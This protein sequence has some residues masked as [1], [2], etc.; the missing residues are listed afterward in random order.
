MKEFNC[1]EIGSIYERKFKKESEKKEFDSLLGVELLDRLP[2]KPLV[3]I[4]CYC[5]NPNHFHLLFK[6]LAENGTSKF[7]QK[8]GTGYTNFFNEKYNRS[9]VLFQGKFKAV[10]ILSDDQ[11]L[12]VSAYVNG[13][14]EIHQMLKRSPTP[15]WE[16]DSQIRGNWPWSSYLDYIG[17][18]NGSLCQK[19]EILADFK[20]V[21]DY[22]DYVDEVINNSTE[23]K[24]E[25]KKMQI[26]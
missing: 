12:Y 1:W 22:R 20:N 25:L 14:A 17:R 3:E 6:Q 24:A 10:E 7:M 26:E 13:N 18:R 11:L 15:F 2:N 16:S 19:K 8:L 4:I 9:G 21:K 23:V 5:L